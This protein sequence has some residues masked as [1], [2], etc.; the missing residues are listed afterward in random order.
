MDVEDSIT[1]N[2]AYA[3]KYEQKKRAEELSKRK[4]LIETLA[5]SHARPLSQ[6]QSCIHTC[7]AVLIML[8]CNGLCCAQE[9]IHVFSCYVVYKYFLCTYTRVLVY[10]LYTSYV[11]YETS[12]ETLDLKTPSPVAQT[13]KRR[14]R[15]QRWVGL[16]EHTPSYN[17][18]Y[19]DI[20]M[21]TQC[22]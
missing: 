2:E 11:Q 10:F 7:T 13:R 17:S 22:L 3:S 5:D 21:G 16:N 20:H 8:W 4:S 19:T 15:M 12:M 14:M 6:F 1:I 9:S 18:T